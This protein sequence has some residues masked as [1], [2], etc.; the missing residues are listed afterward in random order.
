LEVADVF[1]AEVAADVFAEVAAA[2]VFAEV[3]AEVA[4][5]VGVEAASIFTDV[6]PNQ[7]LEDLTCTVQSPLA[8]VHVTEGTV[9]VKET[10]STLEAVPKAMAVPVNEVP[11]AGST[12]KETDPSPSA[13]MTCH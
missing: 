13:A 10:V 8:P 2:D 6:H 4:L 3:A 1:A 11:P 12:T 7:L 5:E 9:K